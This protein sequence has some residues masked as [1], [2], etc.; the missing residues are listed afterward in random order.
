MKRFWLR[1]VKLLSLILA[2]GLCFALLQEYIFCHAD[3][4]R[5]RIKGF[6]L[7]APRT[8]DIVY[9]GASEVYSD[10][11]PGYAYARDGFTGYLFA[12]QANTILNYKSQ[13]ETVLE[14]HPTAMIVIELNGAMYDDEDLSKEANLRNYA[15]NIPLSLQKLNWIRQNVHEDQTEYLFPLLKYHSLWNGASEDAASEAEYRGTILD[16]RLR[17]YNYLKGVLN[18]TVVYKSPEESLNASLPLS[19]DERLPLASTAEAALRDLLSYCRDEGLDNVVFA[20]FPH[21]VTERTYDRFARSNTVG[22]IV[23]EYGYEYLNLE[24]DIA[25]TGLDEEHDFYNA[26]HLNIY[27]QQ[28]LTAYLTDYLT[29]HYTVIRHALNS[30]QKAEWDACAAYYDAYVRYSEDLMD[31]MTMIELKE[32]R[33]LVSALQDYLP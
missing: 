30:A 11:A 26:D 32:N 28:K 14:R 21:I 9:L 29:E 23:A 10:V 20:R 31:E 33:T 8:L 24:R 16:D 15:D 1:T 7:E 25:L 5:E 13:L 19:A 27:G 4:N 12:S 22:D 6:Y 2:L 17:G 3:H 18:W